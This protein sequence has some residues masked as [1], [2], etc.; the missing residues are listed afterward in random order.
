MAAF[1]RG[2]ATG[3]DGIELDVHLSNDGIVVVHH[4]WLLDRTTRGR[5]PL[6]DRTAH[7]LASL[8]VPPRLEVLARYPR[9]PPMIELKQDGKA[10]ATAVVDEVRRAGAED[11]VCLGS[12]SL[13]ALRA[14]R[15]AAPEIARKRRTVSWFLLCSETLVAEP[16]ARPGAV[17]GISGS[18]NKW[19]HPGRVPT[20][21]GAGPQGGTGRARVDGGRAGR[22]AT[23]APLGS[24]RDSFLTD[25]MLRSMS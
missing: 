12:F 3:A 5:G 24:G 16:F 11:R 14:A 19:Q 22:H 23:P 20:I 2:L 13:S 10:L 1:E 25:P 21:R 17:S 8:D 7:E 15:M 9:T 18:G 4:D 6:S